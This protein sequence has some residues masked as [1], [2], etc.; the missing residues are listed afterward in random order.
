MPIRLLN[1]PLA[2][3]SSHTDM[4][5][6]I[7]KPALVPYS[8]QPCYEVCIKS[9]R[10][11]FLL[12]PTSCFRVLLAVAFLLSALLRIHL[13]LF[14]ILLIL[15]GEGLRPLPGL[16]LLLQILYYIRHRYIFVSVCNY[17]LLSAACIVVFV[18]IYSYNATCISQKRTRVHHGICIAFEVFILLLPSVL[19]SLDEKVHLHRL[20][21]PFLIGGLPFL[22][23]IDMLL[24]MLQR[25]EKVLTYANIYR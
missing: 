3:L 21:D 19:L 15:I 13:F 11:H 20:S 2:L 23:I 10:H 14:H 5:Q 12:A 24:S 9:E 4:Q 18:P 17:V 1:V 25:Y 22:V 7:D 16:A 6:L 8:V